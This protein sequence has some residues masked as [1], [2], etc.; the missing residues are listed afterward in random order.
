MTA[1]ARPHHTR[2][3]RSHAGS[4]KQ[5]IQ[6]EPDWVQ[7]HNH[8]IGFRDKNDRHPGLTHV[9]DEW[10]TE[11]QRQFLDQAKREAEE[12]SKEIKDKKLIDVREFMAKQEVCTGRVSVDF[13]AHSVRD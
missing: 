5:E 12:L 6:N 7:T 11:Q 9:G 8:R 3:D 2:P 13:S 1:T 10:H 4:S